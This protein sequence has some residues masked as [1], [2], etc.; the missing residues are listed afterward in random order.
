VGLDERKLKRQI[1]VIQK[2]VNNKYVGTLQAVTGFGKTYTAILAI[3][4]IL[5][6]RPNADIIVVVPTIYLQNQW[7]KELE[8]ANIYTVKVLVINTACRTKIKCNLL[9]IDEVHVAG[10][11]QFSEVFE[12]IDYNAIFCLTATLE[13]A[14]GKE[15]LIKKYS[16]IIDTIGM[17]E[18]LEEGYISNYRLYNIPIELTLDEKK[19]Y[20]KINRLYGYYENRL[21][22]R[23]EA[24]EKANLILKNKQSSS[25][26]IKDAL[27]FLRSVNSRKQFLY[28][29][30]GKL[31]LALDIINKYSDRKT[32]VF[33]ESIDFAQ[34]VVNALP[35][36]STIYH[37]TLSSKEKKTNIA[38][39]INNPNIRILSS[40]KALDTG[41][42]IPNISLG[43]TCAGSSRS[44]Q[45]IQ[46]LGRTIRRGE[47]G[48]KIALFFNIYLKD[49]QE[50]K[51]IRKKCYNIPNVYYIDSL[52]EIN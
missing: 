1:E 41:M 8:Q 24:W 9:I 7:N 14:D 36:I 48:N 17:H 18:A 2:W 44:L 30:N 33:S 46:R 39:F 11:E 45:A 50:E 35:D 29:T 31:N 3:R 37:S 5:N 19:S 15:E 47:D 52:E 51:W 38:N 27:G 25:E 12:N 13:R 16:P 28:N 26:E 40:V 20:Q 4:L 49:S 21:G 43:I 34:K 22:G 23:F 32:V 42:D 6:K 10:A